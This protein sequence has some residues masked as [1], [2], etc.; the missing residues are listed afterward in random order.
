MAE[1]AKQTVRDAIRDLMRHFGTT[2]V[3]GNPGST[4][5]PFLSD[6]PDDFR[7]VLGLSEAAVIAM[8]DGFSLYS[9]T[10]AIVHLHSAGGLGHAMGNLV[11]AY[12]NRTPMILI[13]GQQSRPLLA[14]DPFLGAIDAA[15]YPRPYVKWSWEPTS[16]AELPAAFARAYQMATQP[17]YGPVYLSVPVDDWFQPADHPVRPRPRVRSGFG[18]GPSDVDELVAALAEAQRP[19]IVAG[20]AVDADK[21]VDLLVELAERTRAA[22]FTSPMSSRCSFPE[23]HPQFKGFLIPS[24]QKTAETLAPHDL[25][26]VIGAPAFT[27][28]VHT[29]DPGPELPPV[30]VVNDDP[31]VLA[32]APHGIGMTG[33]PKRVLTQLLEQVEASDRALPAP[34]V[35]PATPQATEPMTGAYVLHT[36]GQ[37]L[38]DNA[39][40]V[41]E[42]PGSR[43]DM[44]DHLPITSRDSGFLTMASGV[45][46][47]GLPAAVG[48]KLAQP[49]RPVV[50]LIGDG[51]SM[52]AIQ[53]LWTAAQEQTP[54]TFVILD[55][56]QYAALRAHADGVGLGKFPGAMLGGIDFVAVAQG[57]GCDG[58]LVQTAA[59]LDKALAESF[60]SDVPTVLHVRIDSGFE[61][62]Y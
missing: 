2:T 46:G 26:L 61:Y 53:A 41:E 35:R 8:A 23:D 20:A 13:A 7:Y 3:F 43:G 56:G 44:H 10:P 57:L 16:A 36:L 5:L 49:N 24:Q 40:L 31:D 47:Y 21:A 37:A 17:P 54:V 33:T 59:E 50:A 34:L 45:L 6:W 42:A 22:V 55:N 18:L 32:W 52:Y 27:Y 19:A 9:G 48:V 30:Y 11:S 1:A 38:P 25:V 58:Q 12:R 39:V 62:P 51:S 28:H 15:N 4:E 29:P 60:A 14:G